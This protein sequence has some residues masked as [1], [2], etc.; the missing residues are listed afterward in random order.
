MFMVPRTQI[1]DSFLLSS[2]FTCLCAVYSLGCTLICEAFFC[3]C[4]FCLRLCV[5][6]LFHRTSKPECFVGNSSTFNS[7]YG[8]F[9]SSYILLRSVLNL[10]LC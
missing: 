2:L 4:S 10:Y 6:V 8:P 9:T 5:F 3:N 1:C 7:C